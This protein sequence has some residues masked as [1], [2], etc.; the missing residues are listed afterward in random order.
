MSILSKPG[1]LS[2]SEIGLIAAH[3]LTGAEILKPLNLPTTTLLTIMQHHERMD[4]TGYPFCLS[5]EDILLEARIL[6]VADVVEAIS[7]HRAY[8]PSL[9]I[10]NAL[11][12]LSQNKG[13]LY[14]SVV[15]DAFMSLHSRTYWHTVF[16]SKVALNATAPAQR[17]A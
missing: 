14:D 9:G 15:V 13:T 3:P 11:V 4:G 16:F 2:L 17:A 1:N 5:G 12:E 6:A 10:E 8:R 7:A